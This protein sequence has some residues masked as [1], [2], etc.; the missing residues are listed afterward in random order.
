MN[1]PETIAARYQQ[2]SGDWSVIIYWLRRAWFVTAVC[3]AAWNVYEWFG[4]GPLLFGAAFVVSYWLARAGNRSMD[5]WIAAR[6]Q[7]E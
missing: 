4:I 1:D 2:E 5:A 3:I 6:A 7:E